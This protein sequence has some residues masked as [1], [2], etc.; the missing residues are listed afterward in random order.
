LQVA[1]T[2][3]HG[4][5]M[6]EGREGTTGGRRHAVAV[7]VGHLTMLDIA[8]PQWVSL[9]AEAGFDAVGIRASI[10]GADEEPWPLW[11]GSPM[12]DETAARLQDTGLRVLDVEI[13]RLT[14][15]TR[16]APYLP[17]FETGAALGAS[18]VNVIA[19]DP[20][21]DRAADTFAALAEVA[22]TYGLRVAVEPMSYTPLCTV[23]DA[24]RVISGSSGGFIVDPLH[25]A[26][27]GVP[28]DRLAT[29]DPSALTYYQLCD[30][31]ARPPTGL[32]RPPRL[33]RGQSV[34]GITDAQLEARAARLLPGD[35]ELPLREILAVLPPGRALSVEAPNLALL[36]QLGPAGFLRRARASV[37]ALLAPARSGS[38]G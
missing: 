10:A 36:G 26:R 25:L 11:V 38:G 18:F 2:A 31:P 8:P 16:P 33:P 4:R 7:G 27:A 24:L 19:F 3:L 14:P 22:Q 28:P 29:V 13:I 20:D 35:G 21:L 23:D 37:A 9:V 12:F 6:Q 5:Q 17:L 1:R 15:Q 30:A 32:V 34:D